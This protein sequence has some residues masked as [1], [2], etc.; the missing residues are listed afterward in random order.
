MVDATGSG[1]N[2]AV[3]DAVVALH[4]GVLKTT[5]GTHAEYVVVDA[6]AVASAPKTVDAVHASTLPLNA[7]TAVQALDLLDLHSG[8]TLLVTGAAGA[9]GGYAVQLAAYQGIEVTALAGGADEDLVRRLGATRFAARGSAAS[10]HDAVLDTAVLGAQA[11]ESVR[12]EGA[13]T[14]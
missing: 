9:V 5:L 8:Q 6:T 3:G 14:G 1:T 11:L 7:L 2:W 13:Y 10:P 4:H 12:D